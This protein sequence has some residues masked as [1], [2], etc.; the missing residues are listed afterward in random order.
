MPEELLKTSP[1]Q[2]A[3]LVE[4]AL[5]D[6]LD[7][8]EFDRLNGR[9]DEV[10]AQRPGARFILDLTS[11]RYMGSAMLGLMVNIRH[12]VKTMNGRLALC[13]M[14]AALQGVFKACCLEKLFTI[15][16]TRDDAL[17]ALR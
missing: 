14:S 7:S 6:D 10:F 8:A 3:Q 17:K 1:H 16:R 15:A 5:P 9:I 4:L 2:Y 13:G 11:T 12:R